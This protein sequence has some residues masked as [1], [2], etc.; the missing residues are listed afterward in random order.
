MQRSANRGGVGV[1][2]DRRARDNPSGLDLGS[3][4]LEEQLDELQHKIVVALAALETA[5]TK[6]ASELVTKAWTRVAEVIRELEDAQW[7][8]DMVKL[9][10]KKLRARK[11]AA[12]AA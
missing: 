7:D 11:K 10:R 8:G 12:K 1:S 2:N 4:M 9:Q 5:R 3:F 6:K